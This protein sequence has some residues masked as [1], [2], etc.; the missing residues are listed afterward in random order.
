MKIVSISGLTAAR[1]HAVEAGRILSL[2]KLPIASGYLFTPIVSIYGDLLDP[3]A[4]DSR[5]FA[6]CLKAAAIVDA[7]LIVEAAGRPRREHSNR[8]HDPY[9][10]E[11]GSDMR[12]ALLE[13]CAQ[14]LAEARSGFEAAGIVPAKPYRLTIG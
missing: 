6:A 13:I 11:Y 10:C 3:E 14:H 7:Q 2:L 8:Y 5:Q 12:G 4:M 1:G 9:R